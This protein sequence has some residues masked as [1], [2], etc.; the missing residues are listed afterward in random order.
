MR[1]IRVPDVTS[2]SEQEERGKGPW[3]GSSVRNCNVWKRHR[4]GGGH[5]AGPQARLGQ[6]PT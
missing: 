3:A 5:E 6:P 4:L 2:L 1:L